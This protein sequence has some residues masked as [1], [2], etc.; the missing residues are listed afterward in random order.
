[1]KTFTMHAHYCIYFSVLIQIFFFPFN[2][3][4]RYYI[5]QINKLKDTLFKCIS[6]IGCAAWQEKETTSNVITGREM[7][8][9]RV[10]AM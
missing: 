10:L 1:M 2:L 9:A 5:H 6:F 4:T 8:S 3:F 7:T